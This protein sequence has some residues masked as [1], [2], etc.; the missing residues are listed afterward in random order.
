ML[1][2]VHGRSLRVCQWTGE[3]IHG[4]V[5]KI[6]LKG[7]REFRGCYGSPS[8][9]LAAIIEASE[10]GGL[11]SEETHE[12]I[13]MFQA[14]LARAEGHEAEKFTIQTA[15]SWKNLKQWGGHMTL[16][17]FHATYDHATQATIFVQIIPS[18]VR[19][20]TAQTEL[21]QE[22]EQKK[23]ISEGA[24]TSTEAPQVEQT[25][26]ALPPVVNGAPVVFEYDS[27]PDRAPNAPKRWRVNALCATPSLAE[28]VEARIA[29]PRCITSCLEFLKEVYPGKTA[30]VVYLDPHTDKTF[31][32]G[33]PEDWMSKG[34][35]RASDVL[36]KTPVYGQVMLYHKNKIRLTGGWGKK[37]K[38]GD[39]AD[40]K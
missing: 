15:G 21:K 3:A 32:V 25:D 1:N 39:M 12:L 14:S 30:V 40:E 27:D 31:G 23:A 22:Q 26:Q 34:N 17:E 29:M 11:N 8:V 7:L 4:P 33:L 6:P 28:P 18:V 10:K 5:F 13:D 2:T 24:G 20:Q 36:S 38:E 37:K 9:G 35:K 19:L 16:D